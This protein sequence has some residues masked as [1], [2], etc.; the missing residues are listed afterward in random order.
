MHVSGFASLRQVKKSLRS[1]IGRLMF[2]DCSATPDE[3]TEVRYTVAE[4]PSPRQRPAIRQSAVNLWQNSV[5]PV[6]AVYDAFME[7]HSNMV[8]QQDYFYLSS[9]ALLN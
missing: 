2:S 1:I 5:L 4:F 3:C 6:G 8:D 7:E 9:A